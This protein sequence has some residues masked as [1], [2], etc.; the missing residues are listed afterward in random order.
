M[1]RRYISLLLLLSLC[2]CTKKVIEKGEC[3]SVAIT[4][5]IVNSGNVRMCDNPIR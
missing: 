4:P 3:L 5:P 2:G 1:S